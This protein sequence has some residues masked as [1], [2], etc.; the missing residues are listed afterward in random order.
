METARRDEM[1]NFIRHLVT[2][3]ANASLYSL[4]HQ[5]V[6]RHCA[7]AFAALTGAIGTDAELAILIIDGELVVGG[8]PL[9]GGLYINRFC[10]LL[11]SR[12]I[13]HVKLLAGVTKEEIRALIT[14]LTR[15]GGSRELH[16]S[17][18]LRFGAVEVRANADLDGELDA[19]TRR[20]PE[21]ADIP[22]EELTRF[23]DIYEAARK[24]QKLNVVGIAEIVSGFIN[25]FTQMAD[26]LLA[27]APLRIMDEY[28]FTHSTNVCI[29]NIAQAMALGIDGPLLHDIGVAAML[30]DIGKL[31]IP[32]E[33]LNKPGKLDEQEWEIMKLHPLK[34]AQY[35]LDTPGVPRIAVVTAFEHH[36]KYDFSGYPTVN[37]SW[38]QNI[39]SQMTTISDFFDALRTKRAYRGAMEYTKVAAL[40]LDLAGTEFHPA[41][42]NN[43][44]CILQRFAAR[45]AD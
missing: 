29:L 35:L 27:L 19:I 11:K 21:L 22:R 18:H 30:H 13:S 37:G 44:L 16:S 9:E 40:M 2:A 12:G 5:Q 26:P 32:E 6:E 4:A 38:Q 25:A 24:R 3:V 7:E 36:M 31:Y 45:H 8:T 17:D 39:C 15:S 42:T 14:A 23:L 1:H 33:I 41:L 43:F 34:G 20:V 10:Q 28:T